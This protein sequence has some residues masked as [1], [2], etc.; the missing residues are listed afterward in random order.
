MQRID[1]LIEEKAGPHRHYLRRAAG[2][3]TLT[4]EKFVH[5]VIAAATAAT[6]FLTRADPP[7]NYLLP[8]ASASLGG[9]TVHH[10]VKFIYHR[11]RPE[12]A[13]LRDKTE[14]AFPSGHTTNATAVVTT[15][16]YVL[17]RSGLVSVPVAVVCALVLCIATGFSRVALG[18]HWGT[19][20][21]GG[22]LAGC[23]IASLCCWMFEVLRVGS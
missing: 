23:G 4:G 21:V 7:L 9:I 11:P 10:L 2:A 17:V 5:P 3:A 13:L 19:D 15:S 14:A 1:D 20:V 12:V 18:W 16:A 8:L 6:L 22:W